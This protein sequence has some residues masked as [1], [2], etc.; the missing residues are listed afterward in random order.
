[1]TGQ[2]GANEVEERPLFHGNAYIREF[3]ATSEVVLFSTSSL[4]QELVWRKLAGSRVFRR[5]RGVL[6]MSGAVFFLG[7]AKIG[8]QGIEY[9]GG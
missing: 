4:W 5:R 7:D 1:M 6:F 2:L 9:V 3:S 8:V